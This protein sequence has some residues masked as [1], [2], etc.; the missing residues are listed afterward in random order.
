MKKI[1]IKYI[2]LA[3]VVVSG[4]AKDYL[5]I[6]PDGRTTLEEIFED[7][8]RT[9]AYLNRVY[10]YIPSYFWKYGFFD[11]LAPFSD[12]AY[13]YSGAVMAWSAGSLNPS[14]S[15]LHAAQER[16]KGV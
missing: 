8:K 1:I 7:E 14:G 5:D 13:A 15:P 2:V 6:T 4:C 9:E 11:F 10:G 12:E 16:G 3:A